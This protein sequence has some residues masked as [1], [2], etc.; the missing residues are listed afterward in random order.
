MRSMIISI[1]IIAYKDWRICFN[2]GDEREE[3]K[4]CRN[5]QREYPRQGNEVE[6]TKI[7]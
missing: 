4:A 3:E 6:K 1:P 7:W 2:Y 5:M